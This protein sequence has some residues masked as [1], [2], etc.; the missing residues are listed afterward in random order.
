[1]H[2]LHQDILIRDWQP[3]DRQRV[4]QLVR[5]AFGEFGL[6][7]EPDGA[8]YDAI[9]VE[10][11]YWKTG[12]EFWVVEQ[13]GRLVGC[14]GYHPC[15]RGERAVELR[16]MVLSPGARGRGL[17]RTLLQMLES[18][19]AQRGFLEVWLET[20]TVLQQAIALYESS[21]YS[22]TTGVETTRCDR[23]Y[24]KPLCQKI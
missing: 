16:K 11:A 2:E 17:G 1:M 3:D 24:V 15:H 7:F 14:G 19:A 10:E 21:G 13:A 12:G 6:A 5:D 23:V 22:L 20:A 18:A 4:S 8:D 9:R